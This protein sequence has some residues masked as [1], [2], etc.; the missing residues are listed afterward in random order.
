MKVSVVLIGQYWTV[1]AVQ[2]V[3]IYFKLVSITVSIYFHCATM[4]EFFD[5]LPTKSTFLTLFFEE[6][7]S[8]KGWVVS[9]KGNEK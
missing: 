9:L 3:S 6:K 7:R 2:T 4:V 5:L 1:V 8:E